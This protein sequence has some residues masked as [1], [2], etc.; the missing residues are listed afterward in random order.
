MLIDT[1]CHL[2]FPEFDIDRNEAIQRAHNNGIHYIINIGSS[3]E[4]SRRSLELSAKHGFIYATCGMHPHEADR[5]NSKI[6]AEL[7]K[8]AGE[9]K[10]V[11]I[12]ET[13]LDYYKNYS[14][15]ENQKRLFI[16]LIKLAKTLALP[17][18]IHNRKAHPDTL[19]I[20]K[21][22]KPLRAVVHC[23]CGDEQFLKECLE[24][25]FFISYTCNI[26]YKKAQG[27]RDLVKITPLDRLLLET[28]APFLPP[29]EFRGK[30]NEPLYVKYLAQEIARIKEIS[31]DE[32]AKITTEN[33]K[34]FFNLK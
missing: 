22:A 28:D 33:A 13:G 10:V 19:R 18:V 34:G 9:N 23:F 20:L 32:V 21:K 8:L 16:S 17:L 2:D 1:H 24:L 30:R 4:G 26:T 3:L 25:G 12:G 31:I 29:E 6:Q 27:L 7:T 14:K 5:F 11:A 15:V